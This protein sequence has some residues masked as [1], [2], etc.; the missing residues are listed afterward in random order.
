[1]KIV[2]CKTWLSWMMLFIF[3]SN[4][5]NAQ[6]PIISFKVSVPDAARQYYHVELNTEGLP[7]DS[8]ILKMPAWTPG[9][10]QLM[11]YAEKVENFKAFDKSGDISWK[12]NSANSW[13]VGTTK[14]KAFTVSYDVKAI[15][16]FVAGN[17]INEERAYLSPTGVF[18]FPDGMI[19][20]SATIS[21]EPY[22][23]WSKVATGLPKIKGKANSFYAENFDV[24]FDSPILMGNLDS[25]PFF[26]VKNI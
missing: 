17:F 10:Y 19:D 3:S 11:N 2:A 5:G 12:K 14:G 4:T 26:K 18:V 7:T 21:I 22:Y 20:R 1:M 23:K 15:H 8:I 16:N 13:K 25:F 24:L 9:Y 6:Q